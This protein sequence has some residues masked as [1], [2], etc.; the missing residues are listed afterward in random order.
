[1]NRALYIRARDERFPLGEIM[2]DRDAP[3]YWQ[4]TPHLQRILREAEEA[5][6][7]IITDADRANGR[8]LLDDVL[9][10]DARSVP[11]RRERAAS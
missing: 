5:A 11:S 8:R 10:A 6:Q 7:R 3:A 2:A 1:V 9:A 4:M